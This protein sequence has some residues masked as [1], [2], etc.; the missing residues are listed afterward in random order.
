[1]HG[2]IDRLETRGILYPL[3][4][5]RHQRLVNKIFSGEL[6]ATDVASDL[7][8]RADGKDGD[9]RSIVLSDED[10]SLRDNLD[11]LEGLKEHC[12]VK[13]IFSMRRQDIWLESWY[14]QNIKWQ[15]NAML[16]HCTFDEFLAQREAFHWI[17]YDRYIQML[18][19]TFG[20]ENI[21]LSVFE[22]DQ[23]PGG[24][25]VHFC[26][27]IGLT[28]LEGFSD[29][30][31]VNSSMSAEMVEF[32]R[33]MPLDQFEPPERDLLRRAFENIDR[34]WLGHTGK[35][36]ELLMA[37]QQR[38]EILGEYHAGNRA[39]AQRHFKRDTLF[40]DPLPSTDKPLAKLEIPADSAVLIERIVAPLLTQ[41]VQ[42]GTI[43]GKS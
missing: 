1:M 33:H 2:N 11:V 39:L 19:D 16:S 42:S 13:V 36:S 27:Q 26:R 6:N 31:H 5:A 34:K 41:L 30:P 25:V 4:V 40:L 35:Q 38:R 22:R 21:L 14:F 29:P 32:I 15:W 17:H 20:A 3:R 24:P 9:I 10:I 18:E 37:P 28:D 12:N 8:K 43:K 23:M 7:V